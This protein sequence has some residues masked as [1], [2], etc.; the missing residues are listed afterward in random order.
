MWKTPGSEKQTKT[1]SPRSRERRLSNT[2]LRYQPNRSH[3][4]PIIYSSGPAG[5]LPGRMGTDN[6]YPRPP[7]SR[8]PRRGEGKKSSVVA[9]P[10]GRYLWPYTV[11]INFARTH[12]DAN[13]ESSYT[14]PTSRQQLFSRINRQSPGRHVRIPLPSPAHSDLHWAT[15]LQHP[16][17]Y[18]SNGVQRPNHTCRSLRQHATTTVLPPPV[19][20][21][22]GSRQLPGANNP[23]IIRLLLLPIRVPRPQYMGFDIRFESIQRQLHP[24]QDTQH[25]RLFRFGSLGWRI[26]RRYACCRH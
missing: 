17:H 22:W 3:H 21:H 24:I 1:C 12:N 9:Q 23:G 20:D 10:M 18:N 4:P 8:N 16:A 5:I 15:T 6:R 26:G 25:V 7:P 14:F 13:A 19:S 2:N 11:P